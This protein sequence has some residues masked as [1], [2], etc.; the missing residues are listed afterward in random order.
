MSVAA[1]CALDRLH[2][3]SQACAACSMLRVVVHRRYVM[4]TA[5]HC[6]CP[7]SGLA[8]CAIHCDAFCLMSR[9]I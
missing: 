7:S 6:C 8:M 5:C 2:A 1:R 4:Q 3:S 9:T